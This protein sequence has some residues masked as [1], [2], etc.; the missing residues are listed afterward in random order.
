MNT[1]PSP[2][3]VLEDRL[4][5]HITHIEN[6]IDDARQDRLRDMENLDGDVAHLCREIGALPME[7]AARFGPPMAE[8]IGRL[9]DLIQELQALRARVEKRDGT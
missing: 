3:G 1:P 4:R 6:A 2:A 9:E 5:G 7:D 8:M